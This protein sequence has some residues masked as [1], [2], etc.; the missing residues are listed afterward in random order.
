MF[1][2]FGALALVVAAVGLY[3][4][5]AYNVA[6]RTQELGVRMALGARGANVRRLV[7]GE[8]VR[9]AAAGIVLG[10]AIAL[11]AGRWVAP[12]L[13]GVSPRDPLVFGSVVA[14]VLG[15]A[16]LAS[17]I[18]AIRASHVDPATALRHD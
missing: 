7:L 15:V 3:G 18:P 9:Y 11:L 14:A 12:L 1:L 5:I 10:G 4:V 13:F 17:L 16:V 8:G 6:Q 2:A